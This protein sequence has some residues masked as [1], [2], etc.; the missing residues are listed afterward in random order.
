MSHRSRRGECWTGSV[1]TAVRPAY[2]GDAV[3]QVLQANGT[4][5][6]VYGYGRMSADTAYGSGVFSQDAYGSDLRTPQTA[7]WAQGLHYDVFGSPD[8]AGLPSLTEPRFGYRGELSVGDD[9]VYLRG[10][11]YQPQLGRFTARD[12]VSTLVG[13]TR[14]DSPYPYADND[15]LDRVDPLGRFALFDFIGQLLAMLL[16]PIEWQ[17]CWENTDPGDSL[18]GR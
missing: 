7:Q 5:D 3:P 12:P 17:N 8:D 2:P 15:P 1:A 11:W 10:R 4:T 13:Q 16:A 9:S 14:P 18:P 6:F